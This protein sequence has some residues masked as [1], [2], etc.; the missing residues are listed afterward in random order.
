MKKVVIATKNKGKIAE[1]KTLFSA[2]GIQVL[3]LFDLEEKVAEIEETG[4]TFQENA[5]IKAEAICNMYN[6]SVLADDSGLIVDALDGS[7]GIYSARYAGEQATDEENNA[8]LLT[9]MSNISKEERTGRFVCVLAI[10]I[11]NKATVWYT[12]YCEGEIALEEKGAN[13]FGYDP[14]F[15]PQGYSQTM[16]QLEQSEKNSIS[17][18]AAALS[19]LEKDI[20]TIFVT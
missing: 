1:F 19:L 6:I 10:A 3:S 8:L 17:H 2:H 9:N 12:G 16:A 15:I 5:T 18:R 14:L 13:G 4:T 11:P 7:P 20:H